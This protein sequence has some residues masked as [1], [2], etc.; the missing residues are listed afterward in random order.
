[1]T[2]PMDIAPASWSQPPDPEEC[3][4]CDGEIVDDTCQECGWTVPDPDERY[5]TDPRV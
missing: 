5:A 1:M 2:H 3:P 4:E